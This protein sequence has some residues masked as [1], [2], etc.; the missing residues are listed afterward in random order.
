M[1]RRQGIIAERKKQKL[2]C[3][4]VELWGSLG[5]QGINY[6]IFRWGSII[7]IIESSGLVW[8]LIWIKQ[9]WII[10][11]KYTYLIFIY[12]YIHV[13]L[14]NLYY[15][16]WIN[17]AACLWDKGMAKSDFWSIRQPRAPVRKLGWLPLRPLRWKQAVCNSNIQRIVMDCWLVLWNMKFYVPIYCWE[18]HHHWQTRIFVRRVFPQPA[19]S[20]RFTII[21]HDQPSLTI[22]NHH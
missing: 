9:F 2:P 10:H 12:I 17:D 5:H 19:S 21:K 13:I 22:I 7:S 4:S 18:F 11:M 14:I 3:P 6:R 15:I 16:I 1:D 20:N 8:N